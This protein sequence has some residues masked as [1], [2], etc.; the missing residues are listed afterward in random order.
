VSREA[1]KIQ[2]TKVHRLYKEHQAAEKE[3]KRQAARVKEAQN[4]WV[5]A[6]SRA[7]KARDEYNQ[8]LAEYRKL[9]EQHGTD[10]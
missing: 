9:I 6:A 4:R 10:F 5:S 2:A 7:H 8:A 3:L 1:V